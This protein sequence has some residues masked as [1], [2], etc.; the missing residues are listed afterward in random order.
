MSPTQNKKTPLSQFDKEIK[1]NINRIEKL[2]QVNSLSQL[3]SKVKTATKM[4][5][6]LKKN[7]Q[8]IF[9]I[10]EVLRRKDLG[11]KI[12]E[13]TCYDRDINKELNKINKKLNSCLE[14]AKYFEESQRGFRKGIALG[15]TLELLKHYNNYY[16]LDLKDAFHNLTRSRIRRILARLGLS[17]INASKLAIISA[18]HNYMFQGNPIAPTLL[19]LAMIPLLKELS[20]ILELE[21]IKPLIYADDLTFMN[22]KS[23]TK[24]QKELIIKTIIRHG[25]KIARNKIHTTKFPI[26]LGAIK[27]YSK[28]NLTKNKQRSFGWIWTTHRK[29]KSLLRLWKYLKA[30]GLTRSRR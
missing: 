8:K 20:P 11:Q 13:I 27:V 14:D 30:K 24:E 28:L 26:I 10:N 23:F 9:D 3:N 16:Q 1:N 17:G 25:F 2:L 21:G 19:N 5:W 4:F 6:I 7:K 12:R 15:A 18:P 22:M 29:I